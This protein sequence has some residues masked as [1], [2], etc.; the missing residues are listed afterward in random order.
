MKKA[1]RI[2]RRH[3]PCRQNILQMKLEHQ[4]APVAAQQ[5]Y[6][7][8]QPSFSVTVRLNTGAPGLDSMGSA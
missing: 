6:F 3:P 7:F 1:G 2:L 4:S 5:D 8:T